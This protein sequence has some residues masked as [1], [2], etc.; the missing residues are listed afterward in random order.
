MAQL[1]YTSLERLVQLLNTAPIGQGACV[2]VL[3]PNQLGLGTDPL[4]LTH[5]ID[6]AR[7]TVSSLVHD[8]APID[9]EPSSVQKSEAPAKQKKSEPKDVIGRSDGKDKSSLLGRLETV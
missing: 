3:G 7:E 9:L 4:H 1:V 5:T 8:E 6:L 2:R